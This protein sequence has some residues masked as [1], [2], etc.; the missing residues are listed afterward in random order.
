MHVTRSHMLTTHRYIS[1]TAPHQ[2]SPDWLPQGLTQQYGKRIDRPPSHGR[3]NNSST[4]HVRSLTLHANTLV[5]CRVCLQ[6]QALQFEWAWQHPEKSKVVRT[7]VAQLKASQRKGLQGKV[8][9]C[10]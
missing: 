6:V 1:T 3:S 8:S 10:T 7:V 9:R 4:G 5:P 2:C